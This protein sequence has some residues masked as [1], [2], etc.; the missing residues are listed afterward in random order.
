MNEFENW[1]KNR[2]ESQPEPDSNQTIAGVHQRII[3][4]RRTRQ[5]GYS[6]TAIAATLAVVFMFRTTPVSQTT[7]GNLAA[8]EQEEMFRD[9]LMT[10][11][12]DSSE[13]NTLY[14]SSLAYL[15]D[16][17]DPIQPLDINLSEADLKAFE[18][19]LEE[20]NS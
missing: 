17:T 20:Q 3:A 2:D 12:M 5:V 14:W 16:D 15:V 10:A 7:H 18:S 4:R 11:V 19:Y 13:L 9:T 1:I 8:F 6:L